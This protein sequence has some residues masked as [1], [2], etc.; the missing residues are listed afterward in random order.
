MSSSSKK[1]VKTM[2][3]KSKVLIVSS[4]RTA[5]DLSS[6]MQIGLQECITM[7][8]AIK[9]MMMKNIIVMKPDI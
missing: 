6:T 7:I 1:A 8:T 5:T 4:S 3:Y 9:K 2:A